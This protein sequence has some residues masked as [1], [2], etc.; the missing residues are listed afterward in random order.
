MKGTGRVITTGPSLAWRKLLV[1]GLLLAAGGLTARGQAPEPVYVGD[2]V[3]HGC[4]TISPEQ[5]KQFLKTRPGREYNSA[6]VEDDLRR[7]ADTRWFRTFHP[8]RLQTGPD[9]RVTV[10]FIVEEHPSVVREVVYKNAHHARPDDLDGVTGIKRG[11]PLNPAQNVRACYEIQDY[12]RKKGRLFAAC[13]L[14]EGKNPGDQRVVFN[15]TEGPV[16]AIRKIRF[17]GNDTLA[18]SP[19]LKTQIDSRKAFLG[20]LLGGKFNPAVIDHDVL[21]LEEYYKAN[22]YLDAR[23][24]REVVLNDDLRTVD[25]IFHIH[26]GSRYKVQDVLVEGTKAI[27]R[28][29]VRQIVRVKQG[30]VYS[31]PAVEG[32]LRNITDLYGYRGYGIAAEK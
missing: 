10:H 4:R 1:L 20:G 17:T 27:D 30:D 6:V 14:E 29:I 11:A 32:D 26:E 15:I 21:K 28:D 31:E 23:V 3:I 24:T 13:H 7:L 8:V 5:V 12:Y 25:V 2:V 22:G 18:S 9:G 19:R 16:V